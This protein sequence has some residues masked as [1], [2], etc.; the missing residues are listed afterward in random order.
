MTKNQKQAYKD[1][2]EAAGFHT[3]TGL[4]IFGLS[5]LCP[6]LA[7]VSVTHFLCTAGHTFTL[8]C[9]AARAK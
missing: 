4:G 3:L 8:A 6:P 1:V 2:R 7:A 5:L 9:D